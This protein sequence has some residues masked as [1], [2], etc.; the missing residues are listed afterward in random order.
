M[1]EVL[2]WYV[3]AKHGM[4]EHSPYVRGYTIWSRKHRVYIYIFNS[5]HVYALV[6]FSM[7]HSYLKSKKHHELPIPDG[8]KKKLSPFFMT[9]PFFLAPSRLPTSRIAVA[10]RIDHRP[11]RAVAQLGGSRQAPCGAGAKAHLRQHWSRN[12][13]NTEVKR[14]KERE[15][16]KKKKMCV[17]VC[18]CI[19]MCIYMYIYIYNYI[20]MGIGA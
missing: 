12:K 10:N 13:K 4:F 2:S 5:L 11:H 8:I 3:R 9:S 14:E 7:F 17:C 1:S 16:K 18:V 15:G 19:D 20:H 6:T